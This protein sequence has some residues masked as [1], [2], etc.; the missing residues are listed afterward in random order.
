MHLEKGEKREECRQMIIW[1]LYPHLFMLG[2]LGGCRVADQNL[3][4]HDTLHSF[5][6]V[7]MSVCMCVC[8]CMCARTFVHECAF[9]RVCM[10]ASVHVCMQV[11]MRVHLSIWV[12][13]RNTPNYPWEVMTLKVWLWIRTVLKVLPDDIG[14]SLNKIC[15]PPHVMLFK[16]KP[17]TLS[18]W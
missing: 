10:C 18:Q 11:S 2:V 7:C 6:A 1:L 14:D 5:Y 13:H 3:E 9:V 16:I 8:M 17:L 4:A 15:T 12:H